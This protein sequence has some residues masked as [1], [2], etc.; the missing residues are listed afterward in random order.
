MGR[1]LKRVPLDFQW[2]INKLWCG[3][4]NP[5]KVHECKDCGGNGYS[6]EY[7]KLHDEWYSFD[8]TDYR[9]NPFRKDFRYNANGSFIKLA[10]AAKVKRLAL[11]V[12]TLTRTGSTA[13]EQNQTL[14]LGV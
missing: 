9:P 13:R 11:V 8:N 10:N 4:I 5:H 7:Q 14:T 12:T 3:Y 2:E 1:K 6:K